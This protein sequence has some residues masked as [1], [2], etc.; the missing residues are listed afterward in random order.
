[1]WRLLLLH[2]A[3]TTFCR[4]VLAVFKSDIP[5]QLGQICQKYT[6]NCLDSI[7]FTNYNNTE[8]AI[9]RYHL[10][11]VFAAQINGMK[12][13]AEKTRKYAFGFVELP[14][15]SSGS[16]AFWSTGIP[17]SFGGSVYVWTTVV[18]Y[19]ATEKQQL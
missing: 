6:M 7:T 15:I 3:R 4:C 12:G 8:R 11:H 1:M 14:A 19:H 18:K 9:C 13:T 2:I 5:A 10:S 17:A 16:S